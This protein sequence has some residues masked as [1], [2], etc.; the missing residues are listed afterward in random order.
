MDIITKLDFM[1]MDSSK[2]GHESYDK[3]KKKRI[4]WYRQEIPVFSTFS[5]SKTI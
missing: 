4:L 1:S 2:K 5:A 3:N